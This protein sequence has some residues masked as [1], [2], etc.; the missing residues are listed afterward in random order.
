LPKPM[1]LL[2]PLPMLWLLPRRRRIAHANAESDGCVL[3]PPRARPRRMHLS[4]AL[5]VLRE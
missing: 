4:V 1:L 3:V 2:T 5:V